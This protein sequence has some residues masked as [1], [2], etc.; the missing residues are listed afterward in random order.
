MR[1]F[2]YY[3]PTKIVFGKDAVADLAPMVREF[4]T[5]VLLVSYRDDGGATHRICALIQEALERHEIVCTPF[6]E[7]DPNPKVAS[8]RRGRELCA[9]NDIQFVLAV[10]GR[11]VI[12]CAKAI[13]V[14]AFYRGDPWDLWSR[15][16]PTENALPIGCVLTLAA[17]GS[18]MNNGSIISNSATEEKRG[19]GSPYIYPRFSIVDPSYTSTVPPYH[20]AAGVVDIMTHVFESYFSRERGTYLQD[21]IAEAILKTCLTYGP[22]AHRTPD[23][24]DARANLAWAGS[25]ALNGL[26]ACGKGF[27]GAMHLMEHA[28]SALYDLTHGAGLAI[29]GPT[30]MRYVLSPDTAWRFAP[31]ARNVWH[32]DDRDEIG[33]AERVIEA[34]SLLYRSLDMPQSLG[35]V[36]IGTERFDEIVE[37]ALVKGEPIGSF[38]PLYAEDVHRILQR[39]A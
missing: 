7:V 36:G 8:V 5:R 3:S 35:D 18:E 15:Q 14:A 32:I 24:Y 20:T 26:A 27:D 23:D 37:R 4:G 16:L 17:S 34:V 21:S 19:I 25:L 2:T 13:A 29:L 28:V 38:V 22:V 10:G 31:L 9:R 1:N 12:D 33:L 6:Y 11:S 39:C 30:W